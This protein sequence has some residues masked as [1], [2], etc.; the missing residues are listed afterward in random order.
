MFE[1]LISIF[2]STDIQQWWSVYTMQTLNITDITAKCEW[3]KSVDKYHRSKDN[4]SSVRKNQSQ[5]HLSQLSAA[6]T[7][8]SNTAQKLNLPE[9][10]L[11]MI[12]ALINYFP[13]NQ[14]AGKS[15]ITAP[16]CDYAKIIDHAKLKFPR[17]SFINDL[18][19]G[20]KISLLQDSYHIINW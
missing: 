18:R 14:Y 2:G 7:Q 13:G 5:N 8:K 9:N 17:K 11:S 16:S 10:N 3:S 20:L 19:R 4:F 15:F 12:S 6:I 1:Y